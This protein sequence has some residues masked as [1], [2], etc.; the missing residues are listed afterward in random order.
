MLQHTSV[1]VYV[2]TKYYLSCAMR[3]PLSSGNLKDYVFLPEVHV[4]TFP[5][6]WNWHQ[7][8]VNNVLKDHIFFGQMWRYMYC[9]R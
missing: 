6:N 7:K 2:Y 9:D 8:P 3:D 1:H 5:Y 4:P